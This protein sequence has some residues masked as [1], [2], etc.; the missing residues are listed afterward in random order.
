MANEILTEIAL[1]LRQTTK[2]LAK[3]QAD[4]AKAAKNVGNKIGTNIENGLSRS[5]S[6]LGR[7]VLGLAAAFGAAFGARA[8]L[9]SAADQEK[10]IA[11]LNQSLRQTGEFTES[12]SKNIDDYAKS[13]ELSTGLSGNLILENIALANSFTKNSEAAK[14]LT[15]V[16]IDFAAGADIN[17]TEAVRRLGRATQGSAADIA[18]YD[19]RI[20]GLTRAQLAAGEATRLL[21]N[22]FAGSAAGELKTYDGAILNLS[23]SFGSVLEEI[24]NFVVK[25]PVIISAINQGA[26]ALR[27]FSD[28]LKEIDISQFNDQ[29]SGLRKV[30]IGILATGEFVVNAFENIL[31]LLSGLSKLKDLLL[32]G[33]LNQVRKEF[34]RLRTDLQENLFN[35]DVTLQVEEFIDRLTASLKDTGTP[36][37]LN[38]GKDA[39]FSFGQG[40]AQGISDGVV[41]VSSAFS[42][43]FADTR[44]QLDGIRQDLR[45]KL[46]SAVK[47]F[48]NGVAGSFASIGAALVNGDDAFEAFGKSI[49]GVFGDLA[50]QLGTFY[51][52]LG[53]ANLFLNPPAAATQLAGG[54]ALI[55]LG[56]A[57]KAI[58]GGGGAAAPAT[59]SAGASSPSSFDAN[60]TGQDSFQEQPETS[61]S[62]QRVVVNIQGNV[63]DR[64]ETGLEIAEVLNETFGTNGVRIVQV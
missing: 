3:V 19:F 23:N 57:L 27:S 39:G 56:G 63:L 6:S 33:E 35:F 4:G 59:P 38:A 60:V 42:D 17:V 14:E 52:T 12:A 51:F 44:E 40:I 5:F 43:I 24:G 15:K 46:T 21:G 45:G 62:E 25:N 41:S 22:T 34:S 29:L 20:R 18:N 32:L 47:Q 1:D 28:R 50:I 64:R 26:I 61:A 13:L 53:L 8:I 30:L 48:S 58:A 16:A 55:V 7:R 11:R 9:R 10:A 2:D 49:L 54:A 37:L 36:K 31:I